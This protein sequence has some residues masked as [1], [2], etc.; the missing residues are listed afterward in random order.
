MG[1]WQDIEE[2]YYA[3]KEDAYDMRKTWL[4]VCRFS[5][6][7]TEKHPQLL[8]F[9]IPHLVL[10]GSEQAMPSRSRRKVTWASHIRDR[11][12]EAPTVPADDIH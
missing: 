12:D 6:Q 11:R 9:R 2:K 3:D 1:S 10:Q 7:S 4:G 8:R 5:V